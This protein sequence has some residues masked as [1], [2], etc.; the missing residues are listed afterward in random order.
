MVIDSGPDQIVL[1]RCSEAAVEHL[2]LVVVTHLHAD[3]VGGIQGV[4]DFATTRHNIFY[5]FR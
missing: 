4:L 2:D 5:R 1:R 3:H